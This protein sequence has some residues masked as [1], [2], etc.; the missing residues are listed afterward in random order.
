MARIPRV[1]CDTRGEAG[2]R[3]VPVSH[4]APRLEGEEKARFP[5]QLCDSGESGEGRGWRG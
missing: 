2:A 1:G 5:L 4:G 3:R